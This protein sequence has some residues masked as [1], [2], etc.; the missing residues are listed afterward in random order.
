MGEIRYEELRPGS[1][2]IGPDGTEWELWNRNARA[3]SHTFIRPGK[4]DEAWN[5]NYL[6][7][8]RGKEWEWATEMRMNMDGWRRG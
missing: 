6:L 3:H 8:E 1:R 4:L 7:G 5:G 2:W